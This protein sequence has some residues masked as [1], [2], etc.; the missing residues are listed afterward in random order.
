MLIWSLILAS[1][2]S[3]AIASISPV[4]RYRISI[5][6]SLIMK[7][8]LTICPY[9]GNSLI[10]VAT[11]V[12]RFFLIWLLS[13]LVLNILNLWMPWAL[14]WLLMRVPPTWRCLLVLS[15]KSNRVINIYWHHIVIH[16]CTWV[17]IILND[18]F[19]W[20]D[21]AIII[22][23]ITI[24]T[25]FALLPSLSLLLYFYNLLLSSILVYTCIILSK[26]VL[27][28]ILNSILILTDLFLNIIN[29]LICF[30]AISLV[31]SDMLMRVT[32]TI[33]ILIYF[34]NFNCPSFVWYTLLLD[35]L[36]LYYKS[37]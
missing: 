32:L 9:C 15:V 7:V 8:L 29:L 16:D 3:W 22:I 13:H 37:S 24:L 25:S 28:H 23:I 31:L 1:F 14:S 10:E 19:C 27:S 6:L 17:H 2:L 33:L 35:L 21:D 18:L 34:L 30:F 11:I 4:W 5:I 26:Q 12:H 36:V 20:L